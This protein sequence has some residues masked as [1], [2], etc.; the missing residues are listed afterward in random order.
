MT[1]PMTTIPYMTAPGNHEASCG[2]DDCDF[3]A[4]NFTVY[5]SRFQM[6]YAESGATSNMW[7][8]FDYGNVHFVTIST[9]TDFPNCPYPQY[10]F[11]DQLDWLQSDLAAANANSNIDWIIVTG[12]QPI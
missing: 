5:N 8:S 3:Y 4:S 6:P 10:T 2:S 7:F 11:G 9:E 1:I 12:H